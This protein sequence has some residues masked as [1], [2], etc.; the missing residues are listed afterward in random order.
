MSNTNLIFF[1]L[2]TT[3][4]N[5]YHDR[6][7]EIAM[8]RDTSTEEE[9][10]T[11]TSLVNPQKKISNFITRITGISNEMV[12]NQAT[13]SQLKE[14]ILDFIQT[15]NTPYLIA[16]NCDG[17]DKLVLRIHFQ[18]EGINLNS[19]NWKYIDTLLMAKKMY[20][21]FFKHNLK[22]LMTQLGLET[23][24]AHRALNDTLM[25]QILYHKMCQDLASQQNIEKNY[26]LNNPEY[27]WQYINN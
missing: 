5:Q 15:S 23:Q 12:H 6:I 8:I 13:F 20:P 2:E 22:D 7:T 25:L 3:G 16:H 4:L 24:T 26:V 14:S 27:V 21:Y 19:Y 10:E 9:S 18:K 1:D 17:F 11:F